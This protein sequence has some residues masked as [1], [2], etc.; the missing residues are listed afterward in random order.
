M[1][2][3]ELGCEG[4]GRLTKGNKEMNKQ[5][6]ID[7]LNM[8]ADWFDTHTWIQETYGDSYRRS[9]AT[10]ACARGACLMIAKDI[11]EADILVGIMEEW[12]HETTWLYHRYGRSTLVAWNDDKDQ[13]KS[14]I[15]EGFR[16]CAEWVAARPG[17][18][19]PKAEPILFPWEPLGPP[20]S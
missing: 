6:L 20:L 2:G 18:D 15:V 13:I 7:K 1:N 16:A 3:L 17:D 11:T 10:E 5:S 8:I 14:N 19:I 4:Q 9:Y 12:L